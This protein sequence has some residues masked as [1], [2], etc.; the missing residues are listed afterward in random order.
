MNESE[1]LL[2]EK[3]EQTRRHLVGIE[4]VIMHIRFLSESKRRML[5]AYSRKISV[6]ISSIRA[7]TRPEG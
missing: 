4:F 6:S 5:E 2:Q 1:G 7:K 3:D